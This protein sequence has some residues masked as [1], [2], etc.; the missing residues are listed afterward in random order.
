M[1]T[2][3]KSNS[4]GKKFQ[5]RQTG[6]K[7]PRNTGSAEG[8]VKNSFKREDS[9][10]RNF[11]G[12][13]R[14][15]RP[16]GGGF[17]RGPR[18]EGGGFNRG[19][20]PEG[21]GFNRGPRPEGGGF[22]RGPRPEG[23]GF[24]RGPRPEGGGFNRGPRPE[25]GGYDRGPRPEGGGFNRG[26]RP[27]GGGFN[28]GPRPEGG[29]Y[30]RGPRPEGGGYNRDNRGG[31]KS[32]FSNNKPENAEDKPAKP[33]SKKKQ[34]D[35]EITTGFKGSK[36]DF[37]QA[38]DKLALGKELA[39]KEIRLNRF[40]ANSGMCSRREA[41]S[42]IEQG[43]VKINGEVVTEL[44]CKVMPRDEV[45]VD[46]K[47]IV[48]EQ[49]V[50]IVLNKPKGYITTTSDPEGRD[51]V[52]DLIDLPGKERIYPV[53]RLDRN[54]TG[55]LL[56][57]NDGEFAQKLT[58]PSFEIKK[59]YRVTLDKKPTKDHMLAWVEGVDLEDGFMS[60]EQVG[61]VEEDEETIL[62]VE[63]HSG[64]N[65]I[66]RRM[67]E[68]FGYEV[69]GLDRVLFGEFDKIKLGRSKWRFLTDREIAYV[70]RLK[71]KEP[72]K[73]VDLSKVAPETWE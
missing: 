68:H 31:F 26:P 45:K 56:L 15:P 35:F 55:V 53:G 30:N 1:S 66:V 61:W 32:K 48:P 36:K 6:E 18:P 13:D 20:R 70:E 65:R 60:F 10:S 38:G 44:G 62:G 37:K 25:G 24:N 71:R 16:E 73:P 50:Y 2:P 42:M 9:G 52:I 14:G 27:E 57:T 72:K 3:K 34:F 41:D 69:V 43:L 29:G 51:T 21:G 28:R 47:R 5:Q 8:S 59:V 19:P 7:R 11:G 49:P 63:I 4:G 40:I 58:H 67:F 33:L 17:N 23:G 54:T 46:D 39:S 12:N 22:N 64:R